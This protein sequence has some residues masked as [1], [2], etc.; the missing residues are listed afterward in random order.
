[1]P[2][3]MGSTRK[4]EVQLPV[5]DNKMSGFECGY[6]PSY[7]NHYPLDKFIECCECQAKAMTLI[8]E[9]SSSV[10]DSHKVV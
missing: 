8:D 9:E 2:I 3:A 4:V 10:I 1:M 6:C 5:E 7:R